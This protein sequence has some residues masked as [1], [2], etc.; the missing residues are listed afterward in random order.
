MSQDSTAQDYIYDVFISYRRKGPSGDWVR[1]HFFPLLE[2]WLPESLPYEP[3]IFID[4]TE[5]ET[6]TDW[7]FVL[8]QALRTSRCL[9]PIW[10]PSY[11]RST[12]CLAEWQSMRA[13][14]QQCGFKTATNPN[15][16]IYP[17]VFHD[18]EHF[19]PEAKA[20]QQKDLKKWNSS[21]PSFIETRG[22][23]E[24]EREVQ[25]ICAEIAVMLETAPLWQND[26]PV[27]TPNVDSTI[28]VQLPR[29]K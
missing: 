27:V 21:Y 17:I 28:N 10:S 7:E 16:L 18:G 24:L 6:G 19:P 23:V 1:N 3:K 13:R 22:I 2:A 9:I 25:V 8:E 11:F 20:T 5:I 14:E 15:G 26:F 29:L 12:W 4:K